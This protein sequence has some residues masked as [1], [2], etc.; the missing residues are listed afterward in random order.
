MSML[1]RLKSLFH[2]IC[3]SRTFIHSIHNN[4]GRV[5]SGVKVKIIG[6]AIVGEDVVIGA[7][8][9]DLFERSQIIVTE[10]AK[11]KI[12]N[13]VGM[14]SVSI[15]CK[16]AITIEDYVN[17]GAGCL[18]MDSNF[19]N[20]DW[21]FR[22][23]RVNDVSTAVNSPVIVRDHVFIGAR[24][25]INKGVTIGARS[26]IASG[27]IVIHDI[28]EDCIAGGNPCKVIKSLK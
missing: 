3:K 22:E 23:N 8:G 7:K 5:S 21:R 6:E 4:Y 1:S 14:T 11:L 2:T 25:I 24:C 27:S 9:I 17:I 18:I 26:I 20:T 13:H 10:G 19:H 15:F 16:E 12:G 28:P